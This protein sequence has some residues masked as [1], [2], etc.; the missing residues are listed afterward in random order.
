[1]SKEIRII[2]DKTN[3][4]SA[5]AKLLELALS[6]TPDY[7]PILQTKAEYEGEYI[8]YELLGKIHEDTSFIFLGKINEVLFNKINWKYDK[9]GMK[10]GWDEHHA[11]LYAEN[12]KL[13]E[14]ELE[15]FE[16]LAGIN[17]AAATSFGEIKKGLKNVG[18][19]FTKLPL[20]IKT[21][22]AVGGAALLGLGAAA[23]VGSSFLINE[24]MN[25]YNLFE[26]QQ[27][28]LIKIFCEEA[29]TE[30]AGKL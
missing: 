10:Y 19:K 28:Y 12:K 14:I 30:F 6:N 20:G 5:M 9:L 26:N 8:K 7:T 22:G 3:N 27:K 1:M 18:D 13:S 21:V 2:Y 25:K 23:L 17:N 29:L 16:K 4:N 11:I 15:E 24:K